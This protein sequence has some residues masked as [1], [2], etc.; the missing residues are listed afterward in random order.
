[1]ACTATTEEASVALRMSRGTL[2]KL[3]KAGHLKAGEHYRGV[4][5][6]KIRPHWLWDIEAVQRALEVRTRRLSLS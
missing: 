2:Y 6:G 4:G 1:M 3:R 5:L